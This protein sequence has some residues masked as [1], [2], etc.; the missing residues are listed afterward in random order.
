MAEYPVLQV[1]PEEVVSDEALGSKTK[2]WFRQGESRWLF[3]E[4]RDGTGED[5]AEKIAS[6]VARLLE[7]P[8]ATVELATYKGRRGCAS[9]SFAH[10]EQGDVLVHGNE[11]L[12]GMVFGYE[13]DKRFRQSDHTLGNITSAIRRLFPED[14]IHQLV[15]ATLADYLAL[16]A[17]IGNTDRHHENWA[18]L[19][20][21]PDTIPEV[22][23]TFDHASSLGRELQ[24][25]RRLNVLQGGRMEGY[26][27]RG[28][29]AIYLRPEDGHGES[30]LKLVE[31][32]ARQFP[33]YFMP[34]LKR[35]HGIPL[36]RY[37]E[38]VERVPESRMSVT[39]KNFALEYMS[40]TSTVL[41]KLI[42]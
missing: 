19:L 42:K 3:K 11:I 31:Y 17:L 40:Y 28:R 10:R 34:V 15:L 30:P 25:A 41:T 14:E 37:R 29:G 39:S 38:V 8:A 20:K 22:A 33:E 9:L 26:V 12:A 16:D 23:P 4:A 7:I 13:R 18:I 5:W 32:A 24:D 27:R 21:A 35:L 2:F 1:L 6:E 36:A